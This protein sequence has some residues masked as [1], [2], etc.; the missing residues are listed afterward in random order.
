MVQGK[1]FRLQV[2]SLKRMLFNENVESVFL[3]GDEGEYEMLPYH[4]PLL[5]ALTEGEVKA[6]GFAP[7]PLRGGVVLFKDNT[8]I[9]VIEES[10]TPYEG[11]GKHESAAISK[12]ASADTGGK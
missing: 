11:G 4:H 8:C 7:I 3:T 2:M 5:G 10:D 6:R 1:T 12:G 9:I